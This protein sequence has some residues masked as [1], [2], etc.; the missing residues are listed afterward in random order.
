MTQATPSTFEATLMDLAHHILTP[1]KRLKYTPEQISLL[2][3]AF[4][5]NAYILGNRRKEL[6]K[7][8][9]LSER[10]VT[11]WFQNRRSKMRREI[12]KQEELE[13]C[14]NDYLLRLLE[15]DS[16]EPAVE[17]QV[18]DEASQVQDVAL[19]DC[20][21]QDYHQGLKICPCDFNFTMDTNV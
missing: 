12:K 14:I 9:A 5:E 15:V 11:F 8:T 2:E 3:S 21:H 16:S 13:R 4:A 10:Q 6:A 7:S 1:K 17:V 20:P 19:V 18:T